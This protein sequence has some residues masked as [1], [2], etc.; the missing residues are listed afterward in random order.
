MTRDPSTIFIVVV[1]FGIGIALWIY[2]G[3]RR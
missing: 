3:R 2:G 1:L